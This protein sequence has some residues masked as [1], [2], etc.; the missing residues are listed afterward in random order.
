MKRILKALEALLF[1]MVLFGAVFLTKNVME[2]KASTV[3]FQPLLDKA[4]EYDV[5]F[6]GDSLI[7]NGIFPMEMWKDYGIASYNMSSYGNTM[8]VTYWTIMNALDYAKPDLIV[9]GVKDVEK[10]YKLSGSSSDMHTA[11]DCYP[12]SRTK[13]RAIED[14]MDDPY[15]EDDD[16][17]RYADMKWE[18]YF[19]LGKY[20]GRWNEIGEGDFR[21]E[22]NSQKGGEMAVGVADYKDYELLEE[23]EADE[24]SGW[25]YVYLRRIIEECRSRDVEVLLVHLPYPASANAQRA[26]N[27]V[28]NIADEYGIDYIDFVSLDQ[29]VD[30]SVDCYDA[31]SHLNPSGARK[32]S[33]YLGRYIADHY[34]VPDRRG[35]A[36]YAQ[37]DEDWQT[38]LKT[39]WNYIEMQHGLKEMLM[40]LHDAD[41]SVRLAI[42]PQA[43]AALDDVQ[44]TLLHNIAR[45]H[46]YEE[47]AYSKWSNSMF[48][49]EALDWA[50][51]DAQ[52]YY[53]HVDRETDEI[54]ERIDHEALAAAD[55]AGFTCEG[56]VR[57]QIFDVHSGEMILERGFEP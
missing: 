2:R 9:V 17:N 31:N 30:Y 55:E 43:C 8:A 27:T 23:W 28:Q 21:Y 18:Y 41:F 34:S 51:M 50:A 13:I 53:L 42:E 40:L 57:I 16:G 5:L 10:S 36:E 32:V 49:L 47:D 25:G 48:P 54:M 19:T 15:A 4:Q 1:C 39:K 24:E 7:V 46:V 12:L 38:Y 44:L 56:G 11:F 20:H 33:D 29:V 52:A 45:E 26:G 22:L 6:A 37:W 35:T 3:R 14:L